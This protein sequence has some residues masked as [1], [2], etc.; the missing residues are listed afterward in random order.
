M[1]DSR[2]KYLFFL[3][4]CYAI[5]L[6]GT[7]YCWLQAGCYW[8][9]GISQSLYM[10]LLNCV[11]KSLIPVWL[12]ATPWTIQSREFSRSEYWSGSSFP[13]PG[14]L[15]NPGIQPKCPML[16]AD[17][18]PV[19]PQGKPENTGVGSLSL[20]QHLPDP[21]VELGSPSLQEDSLPTKLSE[22]PLL[23]LRSNINL[24]LRISAHVT[25]QSVMRLSTCFEVTRLGW[26]ISLS[27]ILEEQWV[28]FEK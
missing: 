20:L 2:N 27:H 13:S 7:A 15:P 28:R 14:D 12:F 19:E 3:R 17:S 4:L 26:P 6:R 8:I 18:L 24:V 10:L 11:W 9:S 22:K 23:L 5:G 1:T 16:Q 21:G 25:P